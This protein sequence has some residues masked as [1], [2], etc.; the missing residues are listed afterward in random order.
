MVGYDNTAEVTMKVLYVED[1][2]VDIDLTLRFLKKNAKSIE[3]EVARS[4]ESAL[5]IIRSTDFIN[6]DLVLTDMHLGDGDGIAILS[7][8]RS[9]SIPIPV[10]LLTGQGDEETAVAALKAG[11]DNYIVKKSGYLE[12]LPHILE[13]AY[14]SNRNGKDKK[15]HDLK[16]L[17]VEHN[18][19]DIDLTNRH[20]KKHAHH[21]S[22]DAIHRV[23]DF[24]NLL[25]SKNKIS[26]YDVLLLDYR[27]PQENAIE[28]L[29][30]LK[31]SE[32]SKIPVIMITGK[33]DEEIAVQALRIGAFDYIT[34]NQGYLHKLPSAIENAYYNMRLEREHQAL[35]ESEQRYRGL[36]E[37]YHTVMFVI[38][39]A[40][41]K[42]VDVNPAAVQFYGWTREEFIGKP[43]AEID[44]LPPEE[45]RKLLNEVANQDKNFF[46]FK[47]NLAD[48]SVRDV[49]VH[50][51]PVTIGGRS[52]IY[53]MVYDITERNKEKR[54]KRRLQ[55]QLIQTQ[56]MESFGQL[57]GGIAHDFNNILSAILGYTELALDNIDAGSSVKDDLQEIYG[58]GKRAR[59]L[60]SQILA[61]ARQ[62]DERKQIVQIARITNEV[63]KLIRSTT[64]SNIT[65]KQD[66][67]TEASVLGNTI[68]I[69]QIIMNLCTNAVHAMEN[70]GGVLEIGLTDVLVDNS[71]GFACLD[72]NPGYYVKMTVS[73]TGAGIPDEI[74]GS[75]FDPYFTTKA[76]GEGT[77]MGLSVVY[78]IVENYGGK[79]TVQSE[80][81]KGTVFTIFLPL[82]KESLPK[83]TYET[84][85]LPKGT[86]KIIFVD[87][88]ASIAEMGRQILERLGYTV[89]PFTSSRETLELFKAK[90]DEYDLVI[91][92]MTMPKLTGDKLAIELMKIRS[93]IPVILCSGYS[94][95][96]NDEMTSK[97]GIKAFANK[98]ILI[99]DLA[100]TV[101]KVL[102]EAKALSRD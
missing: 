11:A 77:G 7:F 15:A 54:E 10:V 101:R 22:I 76:P 33:G 35:L 42:I 78:G 36:F 61:F 28:I 72:L 8:I 90:P 102:D 83:Q 82:T 47:H 96:I 45:Y 71:P 27:L 58:A 56:K 62:S 44:T 41:E 86:E 75:I 88:E 37:N 30:R 9:R 55:Q 16:V 32:F 5:K 67:N 69:H 100:K 99:A 85:A 34:K 39:P 73:D 59:D 24:Y 49:E 63:L 1:D 13:E 87:D 46:T 79:I 29:E 19:V 70:S 40:A 51:G 57:A 52:L 74:I 68:Q 97:I 64:P 66:L 50:S 93:D 65:I 60:V 98:P 14:S 80:L 25:A 38:D 6:Y 23:A 95:K 84:A 48:G 2:A 92:D 53:S 89:T 91:T 17:Y 31:A 4:Q 43:L 20:F 18:Q 81:N 3:L 21:I 12:N 94:K 26:N